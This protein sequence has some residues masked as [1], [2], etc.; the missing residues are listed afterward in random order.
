MNQRSF[1]AGP[2]R[3]AIHKLRARSEIRTKRGG[4]E[5]DFVDDVDLTRL[6]ELA[7]VVLDG[8]GEFIRSDG[9]IVDMTFDL[10]VTR[11]VQPALRDG[12]DISKRKEVV[13]QDDRRIFQP[14]DFANRFGSGGCRGCR[15]SRRFSR[16][17]GR[18]G[19]GCRDC[20]GRGRD[21]AASNQ[22]QRQE[23]RESK[24]EFGFQGRPPM[25]LICCD[26]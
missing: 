15:F 5:E 8:I 25:K 3:T 6:G 10:E 12:P 13:I 20:G 19:I 7:A 11:E 4:G 14:G 21:D 24:H 17:Y 1:G 2:V 18:C 9:S 23:Q 16:R 22:G 26:F